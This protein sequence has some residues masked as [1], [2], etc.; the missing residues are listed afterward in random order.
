MGRSKP[1]RRHSARLAARRGRPPGSNRSG[2]TGGPP[3]PWR[4]DKFWIAVIHNDD[5]DLLR[6][7]DLVL[8]LGRCPWIYKPRASGRCNYGTGDGPCGGHPFIVGITFSRLI[9][10]LK[11][12]EDLVNE[13]SFVL[14]LMI[15]PVS[16]TPCSP[17]D[18]HLN[19]GETYPAGR[20]GRRTRAA[21]VQ[22][23][24]FSRLAMKISRTSSTG[25]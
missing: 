1:N 21:P 5:V 22:S 8:L 18:P 10:R 19:M 9:T 16:A 11:G 13:C 2:C 20:D 14:T 23:G 15:V 12:G 24:S 4:P 25:H 3:S 17:G 7:V 6:A